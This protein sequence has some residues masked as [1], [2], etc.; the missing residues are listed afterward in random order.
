ME[1]EEV[2]EAGASKSGSIQDAELLKQPVTAQPKDEAH[3]NLTAEQLDKIRDIVRFQFDLEINLKLRELAAIQEELHKAETE[4]NRLLHQQF[5]G[6]TDVVALGKRVTRA[7]A[8]KRDCDRTSF[9][10]QQGFLNHCRMVHDLEFASHEE[11]AEICGVPVDDEAEVPYT[12]ARCH[13]VWTSGEWRFYFRALK[14]HAVET[15]FHTRLRLIVGN[16]S[17]YLKTPPPTDVADDRPLVSHRW[18][19]YVRVPSWSVQSEQYIERVRFFLHPSYA[20]DDVVDVVAP[21]FQLIRTGWGEFNVH[22]QIHFVDAARNKPFDYHH[23]LRLDKELSGRQVLGGEE[24]LDVELDKDTDLLCRGQGAE[25]VL[26]L[27]QIKAEPSSS[28]PPPTPKSSTS[29]LVRLHFL[30]T[31]VAADHPLPPPDV[32]ANDLNP[33]R[34]KAAEWQRAHRLRLALQLHPE[35]P[36]GA[37]AA[38]TGDVVQ[39]CRAKESLHCLLCGGAPHTKRRR[40]CPLRQQAAPVTLSVYSTNS[41][42]SEAVENDRPRV[43]FKQDL[44]PV[45]SAD[46]ASV[47]TMAQEVGIEVSDDGAAVSLFAAMRSLLARLLQDGSDFAGRGGSVVLTP[48][49][50]L[51]MLSSPSSTR[52]EYAFLTQAGMAGSSE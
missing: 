28:S 27:S 6:G 36:P 51:L 17:Q 42:S 31:Q 16:V 41:C 7:E 35:Y 29:S 1:G 10:S 48:M 23:R 46:V 11:A 19:V 49:H 32:F 50:V 5:G 40:T 38:R 52:R 3:D 22:V 24:E 33:M 2:M 21:P 9:G 47:Q 26:P 13:N 25:L 20:P 44:P 8:I 30:L 15:R 43:K 18:M 39:W 14:K 4:R 45:T 34:R 12:Q 37:K